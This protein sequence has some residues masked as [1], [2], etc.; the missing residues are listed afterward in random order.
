M[1]SAIGPDGEVQENGLRGMVMSDS[2]DAST[3]ETSAVSAASGQPSTQGAIESSAERR[4]R[5]VIEAAPNA[6]VLVDRRGRIVLVNSEAVRLFG[7][8]RDTLLTLPIESLVPQRHR[9]RHAAYRQGFQQA[10]ARRSMG[11]DRELFGLRA[12][13]TEVP[14]EIGLNPIVVDDERLVLA[15][16]IDITTRVAT[17]A[18]AEDEL[19]R[20]MLD[21]IPFSVLATDR[22]GVIVVANPG[23][24][25]LLGHRG[26][27]LVDLPLSAIEDPSRAEAGDLSDLLAERAGRERETAYVRADGSLVPV[28]EAI[29]ELRD[30]AGAISGYLAVAY[31]ITSRQQAQDAVR[32]MTTHDPLT[33]LPNRT[34]LERRL[35]AAI[36]EARDTGRE[37]ALLL[38]D[39][40][41]FKNVNDSLGHGAG[42]QVLIE[43]AERLLRWAD[44]SDLVCRFGGDEFVVMLRDA[45][46]LPAVAA[47]LFE[48][49]NPPIQVQGQEL[50]T[51]FSVGGAFFPRH[52]A[53]PAEVLQHADTAMYHAKAAGRNQVQWFETGMRTESNERLSL[54]SALRLALRNEELTV[55]YQP[56]IELIT[57]LTVGFEAL[58]RWNS[59]SLGGPVAPDRFIPVAEE[60]GMIVELGA[61]VLDRACEDIARIQAELG[62]PMRLAVNVSPRQFRSEGWAETVIA[63]LERTGLAPSQLELEITEGV[64]MDERWQVIDILQR[65]RDLGVTIAIDDFGLGYSSLAY[66]TRFPIDRI[67]IDRAFVHDLQ[68]QRGRAPIIDAIIV[69]AHALGMRVVA[70]GVE[71]PEQEAYLRERRCDE[72]Q[73]FLYSAAVAPNRAFRA[74]GGV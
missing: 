25:L 16:I 27:G 6:M 66:L 9:A 18:R 2:G 59:V 17:R 55:A 13:G 48:E 54:G 47:S 1:R 70:E 60:T 33:N 20:S 64:L 21:S 38:L 69:M 44:E 61:W 40:D 62:R 14:I 74:A 57:G 41:H 24:E 34:L 32:R 30:E 10:P 11:E 67:K 36:A 43:V 63:T 68:P 35:G 12:D 50:V 39:M 26:A 28:S 46:S 52:G 22:D 4:L 5:S 37:G 56:Q 53:D 8:D 51:T 31:D 23:A 19:R 49:L 65:L 15:S 72:A 45:T 58:A 71:T 73:G 3:G 29:S 42:D 7:Y